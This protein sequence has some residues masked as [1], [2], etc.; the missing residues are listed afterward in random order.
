MAGRRVLMVALDGLDIGVL[1]RAFAAGRLPNLRAW[2]VA[3]TELEVRSDGERLEGTVWPTFTTGTGPGTHGHHWFYQWIADEARFVPASH[4][5]FSVEPFWKEALEA[6]RRVIEFD[7]PYTLTVG[8]PNERAYNGW[9]LQDEMAEFAYP[10]SFRKEIL[11]RHGRSKVQKD[12]LLV[13]TPEDRLRLARRLRSATRQR[14]AVLL[15]LAER[16]DWDLLI[17]GFGELHLGGHH[18][19][20][21][22]DLSPKVTNEAAMYSILRPLDDAWP[23]I[24]RAA[25]DDC[26]IV[27]FALHGMRPKV[28]YGEAVIGMLRTMAGQPLP[29]PPRDDLLRR[30]RNLVPQR[31]HQAIWLRL[32][33]DLRMRRMMNAWL[34]RMDIH[35]DKAFVFEGDC[36]VAIRLNIEG[37][38]RYG[39]LPREQS[40]AHLETILQ[41]AKRYTAE[42]GQKA[43]V[44]LF[45]TADAFHGPRQDFLPDGCLIYNPDVVRARTLTRD[46]GF[47]I[48]LHGAESRNG[49]HTGTGFAFYQES[50]TARLHRSQVD[51]LDFAPTV[52]Q[53]IGVTPGTALEGTPFLE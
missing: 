6:G 25:G 28:S 33:A 10:A 41:E 38:E 15:D 8:H 51:N 12:T 3:N 30:A 18:L 53:R 1:R 9:G 48:Q 42:D 40:R 2:A 36:A 34:A 49:A 20:L 4:P 27:L 14:S 26:D 11:Q 52:L 35:N 31:L 19:S 7:M 29:E 22:M 17:F 43:F 39:V 13:R 24:V 5:H 45:V 46:D 37:R 16:R 50:G 23:A 32:P 21:P 44:D 47:Q